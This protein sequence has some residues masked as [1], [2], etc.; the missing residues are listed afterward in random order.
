MRSFHS[1][2]LFSL[3]LLPLL[4][5]GPLVTAEEKITTDTDWLIPKEGAEGKKMGAKVESIT[6]TDEVG[7]YR[8]EV[9]IPKLEKQMEEVITIGRREN[10]NKPLIQKRRFEVINDPNSG[11]SGVV[12]YLG[13]PETFALKFNYYEGETEFQRP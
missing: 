9:S 8:I 5:L 10:V 12:I 13:K 1:L 6:E 4:L 11:R 3:F 7:V 2:L